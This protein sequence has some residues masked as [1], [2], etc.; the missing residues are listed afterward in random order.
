MN[1]QHER[2]LAL[3]DTLALP[4]VAQGYGAAAQ[5]AARTE[6]AYSDFLEELLRQE[7]AGRKV[8][9]QSMMTRLAGFPVIKTLEDFSDDFAKGVKRSQVDE[10]AG[11]GF[12][13]R[14]ENVVLVGPAAWARHTW[15]LHWAIGRH[16]RASR[17][18]S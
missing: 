4:F 5:D 11:L 2:M 6:M 10:L 9:K 15:R 1:L 16:K 18:V 13:E 17:P 7:I 12:V 3:C 8:R 14:R